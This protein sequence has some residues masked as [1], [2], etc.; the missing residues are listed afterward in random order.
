MDD[1]KAT[2]LLKL[3]Q[4]NNDVLIEIRGLLK[5]LFELVD[6]RPCVDAGLEFDEHGNVRVA[7]QGIR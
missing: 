3:M 7:E 1:E 6:S 5:D 4:L 2:L